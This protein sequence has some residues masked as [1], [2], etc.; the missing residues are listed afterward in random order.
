MVILFK[1]LLCIAAIAILNMD[2][3][4][5]VALSPQFFKGK[6]KISQKI[7]QYVEKFEPVEDRN[8][9][10]NKMNSILETLTPQQQEF[11]I[12]TLN[13]TINVN[14][15]AKNT[16]KIIENVKNFTDIY[17]SSD[18]VLV[19]SP[20]KEKTLWNKFTD[21]MKF[22]NVSEYFEAALT[23]DQLALLKIQNNAQSLKGLSDN[24]K[25]EILQKLENATLAMINK[26]VADMTLEYQKIADISFEDQ[27][28]AS[29]KIQNLTEAQH[30]LLL[31]RC[32]DILHA[33]DPM[34]NKNFEHFMLVQDR[35]HTGPLLNLLN[36]KDIDLSKIDTEDKL[37]AVIQD[38]IGKQKVRLPKHR[39]TLNNF[40]KLLKQ[41]I[42]EHHPDLVR[43]AEDSAQKFLKAQSDD[44]RMNVLQ[45]YAT[46]PR[47]QRQAIA[48]LHNR[49]MESHQQKAKEMQDVVRAS[50]E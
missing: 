33:L 10:I 24:Q 31:K 15:D 50:V 32:Q 43:L 5:V 39:E 4:A 48:I 14:M 42:L 6:Y 9:I 28:E 35:E 27:P 34:L 8:S 29:R 2:L 25:K 12:N 1:R 44:E 47:W 13:L 3:Y 23:G 18:Y 40:P 26:I 36:F 21:W 38:I 46:K 7:Q 45:S 20:Q 49:Y 37:D 30:Y 16:I 41:E 11:F 19:P 17:S 22:E